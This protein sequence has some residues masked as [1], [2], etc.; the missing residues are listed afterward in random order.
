MSAFP[1]VQ[2]VCHV[3]YLLCSGVATGVELHQVYHVA[4][5]GRVVTGLSFEKSVCVVYADH[6]TSKLFP[7][8]HSGTAPA[9]RAVQK[10]TLSRSPAGMPYGIPAMFYPP[11]RVASCA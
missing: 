11:A 5:L 10:G 3:A 9:A 8:L 4:Y 1:G 7:L 2:Q 6:T